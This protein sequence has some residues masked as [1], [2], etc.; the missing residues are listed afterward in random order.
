V[1]SAHQLHHFSDHHKH[2]Y[3]IAEHESCSHPGHISENNHCKLCDFTFS[4][5]GEL[6]IY[7]VENPIQTDFIFKPLNF[8]QQNEISNFLNSYKQLRAPPFYT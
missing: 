8:G 5:I 3:E 7:T 6:V 2:S 1:Q 4:P